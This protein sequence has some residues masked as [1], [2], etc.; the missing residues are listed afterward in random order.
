MASATESQT[1]DKAFFCKLAADNRSRFHDCMGIKSGI[2]SL[3]VPPR[4]PTCV[5]R[6]CRF[7][8]SLA[9]LMLSL[10]LLMLSFGSPPSRS[11]ACLCVC[12][13]AV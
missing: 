5:G 13:R 4:P 3:V 11:L 10:A 7:V 6:V 8:L 2:V 12:L 9:L 1:F